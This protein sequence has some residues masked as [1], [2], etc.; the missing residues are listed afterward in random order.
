[1]IRQR[2][3]FTGLLIAVVSIVASS[4]DVEARNCRCQRGYRHSNRVW[5]VNN[6]YAQANYTTTPAVQQP[7]ATPTMAPDPNAPT[8]PA[9]APNPAP[10]APTAPAPT[11]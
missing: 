2:L 7:A 4:G 5:G 9:Q 11:T 1:M 10:A 6:G 3:I 8:P